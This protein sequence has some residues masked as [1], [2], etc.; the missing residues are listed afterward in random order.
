MIKPSRHKPRWFTQETGG[1]ET[2]RFTLSGSKTVSTRSPR[3]SRRM[4][5]P[6]QGLKQSRLGLVGCGVVGV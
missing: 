2:H 5:G 4:S 1:N 6:G 3:H